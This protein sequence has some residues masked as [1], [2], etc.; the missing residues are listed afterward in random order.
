MR[1][2]LT[3]FVL[4]AAMPTAAHAQNILADA[5][6][7][8]IT[9]K[10]GFLPDPHVIEMTAGGDI[11]VDLEGCDYGYVADAPDAN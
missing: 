1:S 5:T 11:E 10:S 3:V 2:L 7:S 8:D 6:Y 4:V 9:L